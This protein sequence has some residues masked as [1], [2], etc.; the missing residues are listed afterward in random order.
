[1]K[2]HHMK[3][4]PVPFGMI[5]RGEK[6][7]EARLYDEKRRQVNLGDTVI[8]SQ[9]DD[10]AKTCEAKVVG[11]L[12]YE[13]FG[14]MFAHVGAERFGGSSPESLAETM[15]EYYD[16]AKQDEYGVLGIELALV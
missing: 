4:A 10:P 2:T 6:T 14:D 11:L 8:F 7:C 13:T 15:V 5:A 3:L 16:Q 1:M 12:R 9:I